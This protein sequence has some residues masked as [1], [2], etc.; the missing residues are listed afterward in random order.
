MRSSGFINA[1]ALSSLLVQVTLGHYSRGHGNY[2]HSHLH[3]QQA[4]D[5]ESS[6][7]QLVPSQSFSSSSL[8]QSCQDALY[9]NLQCDSYVSTL[10]RPVWHG[11]LNDSVL[12]D[13]VCSTQCGQSL[14]S[15]HDNVVAQCGAD[16]TIAE[17]IPALS[18]IDSIWSGWNET[19]LKNDNGTYCNDVI[20]S[21]DSV[22][23]L[24]DVPVADICDDCWIRKLE[25]MQQSPYSA[26]STPYETMLNYSISVCNLKGV[27]TQPTPGGL[28]IPAAN[29]TCSTDNWYT[30]QTGDTCDSISIAHSISSSTLYQINPT[31][32]NCSDPMV[33]LDLCLP[34]AC[35]DIYEVVAGDNCSSIAVTAGISWMKLISYNGMVDSA[36][37]NVADTALLGGVRCVSP[38]GGTFNLTV[39]SN[40][41]SASGVDGQGGSGSGYG[42]SFVALP[43]DVTLAEGTTTDCGDYYTV[44]SGDTC[45]SL[46]AEANTPFNLFMAANPSITSAAVCDDE[47]TVGVTYCIHPM[48]GFNTT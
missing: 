8:P 19:C 33:G 15:F 13:A 27:E 36:C 3:T 12:T 7:F 5:S 29:A 28:E 32:Y 25:L 2:A 16:A 40:S 31:L 17:G 47:L 18:V 38:P 1:F 22:S 14:S 11:G 24:T 26:Y 41:S 20:D 4:R 37:S 10:G 42:T 39:S 21:W 44:V 6:S 45:V 9:D 48:S 35:E 46:L 43:S 34:L 23:N 30:V